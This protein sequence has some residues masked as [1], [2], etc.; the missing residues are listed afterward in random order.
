MEGRSAVMLWDMIR[1]EAISIGG[2]EGDYALSD[3][4][5]GSNLVWKITRSWTREYLSP[6]KCIGGCA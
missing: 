2:G 3:E 5:H 1:G 6:T 4:L